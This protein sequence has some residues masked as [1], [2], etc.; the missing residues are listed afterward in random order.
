MLDLSAEFAELAPSVVARVLDA[1]ERD[2]R[3]AR[4]GDP[5]QIYVGG[6]R[7]WSV[8]HQPDDPDPA[9]VRLA[10]ALDLERLPYASRIEKGRRTIV[11]LIPVAEFAADLAESSPGLDE[12]RR[13]VRRAMVAVSCEIALVGEVSLY[14][15]VP[16]L[17]LE[18]RVLPETQY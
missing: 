11:I 9:V 8:A 2:G 12:L 14:Q 6:V 13:S 3:I 16:A 17:P 7:F 15:G 4:A 5:G 1:L 10:Q 18:L